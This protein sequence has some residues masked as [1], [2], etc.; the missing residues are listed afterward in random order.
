MRSNNDILDQLL[1]DLVTSNLLTKYERGVWSANSRT[2]LYIKALPDS[3]EQNTID[4]W[5]KSMLDQLHIP[6]GKYIESC[7]TLRFPTAT[8]RFSS[9]VNELFER[10]S[11]M[12]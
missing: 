1:H 12:K 9:E 5:A 8:A 11:Y 10:A 6:W 4:Q 3:L 2:D 7:S